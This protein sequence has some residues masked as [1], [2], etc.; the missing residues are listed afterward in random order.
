VKK[1]TLSILF[2]FFVSL[3]ARPSVDEYTDFSGIYHKQDNPEEYLAIT[4]V[5][6]EKI[7][8]LQMY[9]GQTTGDS[10]YLLNGEKIKV[11]TTASCLHYRF[12][13]QFEREI[14]L[15]DDRDCKRNLGSYKQN[16]R[17]R[18]KFDSHG[19]LHFM[20][21]LGASGSFMDTIYSF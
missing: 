1:F 19:R 13:E 18:L 15:T 21:S 2:L 10:Q 6:N 14:V 20:E 17:T 9:R 16:I 12:G 5:I 8:I 7:S 4:H 3:D 11:E